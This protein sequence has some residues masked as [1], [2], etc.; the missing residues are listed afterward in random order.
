MLASP[1]RDEQELCDG[2]SV[3]KQKID[4]LRNLDLERDRELEREYDPALL[5][6]LV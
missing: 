6:H 5:L 3:G 1:N 2:P 4:L